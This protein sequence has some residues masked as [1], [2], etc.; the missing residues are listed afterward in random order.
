[1]Q[2]RAPRRD[3]RAQRAKKS[4]GTECVPGVEPPRS[5][6][7]R[8]LPGGL[9]ALRVLGP[10]VVLARLLAVRVTRQLALERV[11]VGL[12]AVVLQLAGHLGVLRLLTA[13]PHM[14]DP[15]TILRR[16]QEGA[17]HLNRVLKPGR[18][19]STGL[20]GHDGTWAVALCTEEGM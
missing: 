9:V 3:E 6:G 11:V 7:L 18:Y 13:A 12:R 15:L 1:M 19:F 17:A 16:L 4:P 10:L 2:R 14:R 5:S 20:I 8:A